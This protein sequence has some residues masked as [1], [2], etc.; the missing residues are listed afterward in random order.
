MKKFNG[1]SLFFAIIGACL[2]GATIG[3]DGFYYWND[4]WIC[5]W[6]L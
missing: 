1:N 6:V 3:F 2:G 5:I 4:I